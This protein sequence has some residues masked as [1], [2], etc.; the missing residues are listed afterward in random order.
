MATGYALFPGR[1]DI[2]QLFKIFQRRGTPNNDIWPHCTR[3]PYYQQEFPKWRPRPIQE[4][5]DS[6]DKV[7]VHAADLLEQL[8]QYDPE[9]RLVCK[10]ALSHPFFFES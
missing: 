8:L 10:A 3:L 2:D 7:S 1:S 5:M 9:K 4:F 6:F